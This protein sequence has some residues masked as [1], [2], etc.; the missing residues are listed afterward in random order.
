MKQHFLL[1]LLA[2]ACL[3]PCSGR[4]KKE[5][6][7]HYDIRLDEVSCN[8][9]TGYRQGITEQPFT[10]LEGNSCCR[11]RYEDDCISCVWYV[12]DIAFN[13]SLVNKLPAPMVVPW[14]SVS[15]TNVDKVQSGVGYSLERTD[16]L[17]P[18][19]LPGGTGLSGFVLPDINYPTGVEKDLATV[20][21]TRFRSRMGAETYC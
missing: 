6:V 7:V 8:K 11:Y 10:D 2:F 17:M 1:L 20:L 18:S 3:L 21:P 5:Y 13:F 15:I 19:M 14:N 9:N 4:E 12:S 16:Q